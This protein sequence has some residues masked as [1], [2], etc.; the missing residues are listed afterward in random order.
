VDK[1]SKADED[2]EIINRIKHFD[3]SVAEI[4]D[5]LKPRF[6]PDI[7]L[8]TYY[9]RIKKRIQR[10][11]A[12]GMIEDRETEPQPLIIPVKKAPEAKAPVNNVIPEA[13]KAKVTPEPKPRFNPE[14]Q[15]ILD[16]Q[17]KREDAENLQDYA[18]L[19]A[20][21]EIRKNLI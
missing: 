4:A 12:K 2:N 13:P 8:S 9:Q 1:A 5:E 3:M 15:A 16:E 10:L 7:E 20:D 11:K 19:M 17:Q 21:I 18:E 6:A 14:V